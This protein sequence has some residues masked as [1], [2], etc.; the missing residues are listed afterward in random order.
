MTVTLNIP[1]SPT[2]VGSN[3]VFRIRLSVNVGKATAL[4]CPMGSKL[5]VQVK[6][7]VSVLDDTIAFGSAIDALDRVV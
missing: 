2:L 3:R 6:F 5:A 7:Y 4:S 1:I